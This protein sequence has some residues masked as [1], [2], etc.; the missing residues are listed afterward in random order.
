M[1]IRFDNALAACR[2]AR[3][4]D[5]GLAPLRPYARR[6]AHALGLPPLSLWPYT[7]P[8]AARVVELAWE[9]TLRRT[10]AITG[11]QHLRQTGLREIEELGDCTL[12]GEKRFQPLFNPSKPGR[13]SYHVVRCPSCGLLYRNPGI[14]PE[15]LGE[16]YSE[17]RYVR[18][19]TGR[20]GR[21]RQC[22]YAAV[23]DAF[24][25]LFE[26]GDGRRLLDFG[27]GVGL[28]LELAHARGFDCYGVDLSPSA[29]RMARER[30]G[31]ENAYAGAPEEVPEIAC[32][33]FDVVTMWS[34]LA[35]L[36][37]P[38]DDLATLRGLLAPDGMLLVLT[39]N[40]SSLLLKASRRRWNGFTPNH[41]VFF[42]PTTLTMLLRQAG[43]GALVTR[44]A[45]GYAIERGTAK[46]RPRH[47]QRLRRNIDRGNRGNMLRAVAFVHPD[48]P[49][50]WGLKH[51]AVRLMNLALVCTSLEP[52]GEPLTQKLLAL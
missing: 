34:V 1:V 49:R 45:Y 21:E 11:E 32:G 7:V 30:P 50:G 26:Q 3:K 10:P 15:R 9:R 14:R 16:L 51:R 42:S 41:L 28:F 36:P 31:G 43:F 44:P 48:G 46:I 12:C 8:A 19:L 35:H 27:C 40:A 24:A 20:Y 25:P 33:G 17:K 23:M 29:V 13:L 2:T 4:S 22:H 47:Q 5:S 37:R 18:F 6:V 39:V 38:V 52:L